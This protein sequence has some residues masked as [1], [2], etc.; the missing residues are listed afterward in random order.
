MTKLIVAFRNSAK[1]KVHLM[2]GCEDP[3][4]KWR[5]SSILSLT[6]A[7]DM[8]VGSTP[9]PGRFT[10]GKETQYPLYRMLVLSQGWSEGV[11]KISPPWGFD[12]RTVKLVASCYTG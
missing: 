7:V 10:P 11:R 5:Y 12:S 1:G 4:G 2:T 3:E 8:G 9:R 6:S